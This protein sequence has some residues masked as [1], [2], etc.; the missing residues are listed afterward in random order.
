MLTRLNPEFPSYSRMSGACAM[1]ATLILQSHPEVGLNT[2]ASGYIYYPFFK[3]IFEN[4]MGI[5]ITPDILEKLQKTPAIE[6][7]SDNFVR[8]RFGHGGLVIATM[9][10]QTHTLYTGPQ[11]VFCLS[12]TSMD[13]LGAINAGRV[14]S[15][16]TPPQ[17]CANKGVKAYINIDTLAQNG[18]AVWRQNG[19]RQTKVFCY[20][21]DLRQYVYKIEYSPEYF[22]E[23][24][25]LKVHAKLGETLRQFHAELSDDEFKKV[26]VDRIKRLVIHEES[27]EEEPEIDDVSYDD[28]FP[29]LSALTIKS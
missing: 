3:Q 8:A 20:S 13:G 21:P 10:K 27:S 2:N 15:M 25:L 11:K 16:L 29:P 24:N 26:L 7:H 12:H 28:E 1:Q 17:F 4:V 14:V 9:V 22:K 5:E 6:F 18:I 19:D 23:E